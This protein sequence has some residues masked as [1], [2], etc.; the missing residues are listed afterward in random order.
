M[1]IISTTC[2]LADQNPAP[3]YLKKMTE[4]E[5]QMQANGYSG[6]DVG[7]MVLM[8]IRKDFF[9]SILCEPVRKKS[10]HMPTSL[11]NA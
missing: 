10:G 5:C 3:R 8:I 9:G 2:R 11:L 7:K 6:G 4:S 1:A